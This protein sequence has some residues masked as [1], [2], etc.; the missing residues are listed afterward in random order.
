MK[1]ED[2]A[3]TYGM[4]SDYLDNNTGRVYHLSRSTYDAK[5]DKFTV[6]VSQGGIMIG[7]CKLDADSIR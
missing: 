4:G 7:T 5:S 3:K 2:I 6:P 1:L